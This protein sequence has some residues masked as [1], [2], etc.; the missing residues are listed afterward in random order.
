MP[1]R[2]KEPNRSPVVASSSRSHV[3]D[4]AQTG[5]TAATLA[6]CVR[7]TPL[8]Q[9]QRRSRRDSNSRSHS[10][11]FHHATRV[12]SFKARLSITRPLGNDVGE[13]DD[14]LT[15]RAAIFGRQCRELLIAQA[16]VILDEQTR[17]LLQNY[18]TQLASSFI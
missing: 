4:R 12:A 8:R 17:N 11:E 14:D 5:A 7:G 10:H 1:I 18:L 13:A 15:C 3:P 6:D 2:E 16:R 9:T